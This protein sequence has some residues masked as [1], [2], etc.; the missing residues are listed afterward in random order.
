MTE[1]T[2]KQLADTVGVSVE[3]LLSQFKE[4]GLNINDPEQLVSDREKLQLL[5]F[6]K[7]NDGDSGDDDVVVVPKKITLRRK[8][9][10]ELKVAGQGR[11]TVSVEVRKKR[12]Y[13]KREKTVAKEE[14][15]EVELQE[16]NTEE[17]NQANVNPVEDLSKPNIQQVV[18]SATEHKDKTSVLSEQDKKVIEVT[19]TEATVVSGT[20]KAAANADFE[21]AEPEIVDPER[22]AQDQIAKQQAQLEAEK[23]GAVQHHRRDKKVKNKHERYR[24]GEE[25]EFED[26]DKVSGKRTGRDERRRKKLLKRSRTI[27]KIATTHAF[28][29]PTAPMIHEVPISETITVSDLAQRMSVKVSEVIKTMMNMGAIVTI[30]QVIDQETAI[31]VVEE[32]GHKAK[33]LRSNALE[34]DLEIDMMKGDGIATN[35]APVVTIMGHVDHGKTS[36]LDYIRR[37]KVTAG[38]AGGI[39][40]HIGAYHVATDKGDITFLDTPGHAAFTA[41]R[42]RGAKCTDIVVLIVAADDGVKPQTIEAIQHAKAA[43]VPILV[44]VNKIDKPDADPERVKAELANHNVIAESWGGDAIFVNIS[45]KTGQGV[46]ALLDAILV[47]AEVLELK[48][49]RDCPAR[50]VVIESRLD[51]GHGPVASIM[52]QNGTLRKGDI[53]L[54]GQFYG[55]VRAM[56][57]EVGEQVLEAGPSVP[58]EVLGLSGAP[59]AGDNAFVVKDE[60]KAR[61]VALFRQGKFREVHLARREVVKL[62]NL[63]ENIAQ[64]EAKSLNIVLKTDVQGSAEA[65]QEALLKL[66]SD[67]VKVKI[68]ASSVGGITESDINLAI[69]SRAI[70]IGFN[71][72]ADS[73]AKRLAE[74]EGIALNY[75]S[76]I[77]NVIDEVKRAITGMLKPEFREQ[78]VGLATVREVFRSSK[79]GTVAGCKVTEGVIKRNNPV[80][81]LRDNVVI[82]EGEL[83]SL[84]RFKDDVNEVRSGFECGM[85]VKDYNDIKENDQIEV[86]ERVQVNREI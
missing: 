45:A 26:F 2:V 16:L 71:V 63:F 86:Y 61:E 25:D 22:Q 24:D 5:A 81:I 11:K 32:M 74:S 82:F 29:K 84:R 50:G 80:R 76:I 33:V 48:A 72:R 53:L 57:N 9:V 83:S 14:Q 37:T 12:T 47:Q 10:S 65:L 35:R 15:S 17:L 31:I 78:I 56:L 85:G 23:Q 66:S 49:V 39:T 67:E 79:F 18:E 75:Y 60:R 41:M 13:V 77:Y 36:L 30:N 46:D 73:S 68:I 3:R 7:G 52:V 4:A 55:K 70:V 59:A 8:S 51:K 54:A 42:A 27:D 28:E 69:A 34:E 62:D 6:L 43:E 40:Q 64:G 19:T 58:V 44:A 21:I 1:S 20:D 38:E